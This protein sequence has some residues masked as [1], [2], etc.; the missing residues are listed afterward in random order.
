MVPCLPFEVQHLL[1]P[2]RHLGPRGTQSCSSGGASKW[3]ESILPLT[4]V[5]SE[6]FGQPLL[7]QSWESRFLHKRSLPVALVVQAVLLGCTI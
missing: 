2:D 7:Q 4:L 6:P 5:R 1:R 3:K